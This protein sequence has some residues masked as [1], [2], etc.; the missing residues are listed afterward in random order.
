M[1]KAIFDE[2]VGGT[3]WGIAVVN[4]ADKTT[5][6]TSIDDKGRIFVGYSIAESIVVIAIDFFDA[7]TQ[8]SGVFADVGESWDGLG[9][10]KTIAEAVIDP[11]DH[12]PWRF[13]GEKIVFIKGA[14]PLVLL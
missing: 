2:P 8:Y 13:F 10:K 7:V 3:F 11:F 12:E 5:G 1:A 14:N 4:E 6:L 9:C